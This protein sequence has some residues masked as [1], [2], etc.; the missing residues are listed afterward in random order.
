[1]KRLLGSLT[2]FLIPYFYTRQYI[3]LGDKKRNWTGEAKADFA[4]TWPVT[5]LPI[6]HIGHGLGPRAFWGPAQKAS[7][8]DSLLTQ[9]LGKHSEAQL[10]DLLWNERKC[11]RQNSYQCSNNTII[12]FVRQYKNDNDGF[13]RSSAVSVALALKSDVTVILSCEKPIDNFACLEAWKKP[14]S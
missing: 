5:D 12:L 10:R 8:N 1:M 7:Y 13:H 4:Y 2:L 6:G 9:N 3:K 11:K 14:L